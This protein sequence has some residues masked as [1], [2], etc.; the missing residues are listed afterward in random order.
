MQ[1]AC[2]TR[3]NEDHSNKMKQIEESKNGWNGYWNK[4]LQSEARLQYRVRRAKDVQKIKSAMVN[5]LEKVSIGDAPRQKVSKE[6]I[7]A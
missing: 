5:I 6:E 7:L 4:V 1:D 2:Y 3:L